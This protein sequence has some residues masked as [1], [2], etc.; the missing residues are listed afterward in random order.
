[1]NL[2]RNPLCDGIL[3]TFPRTAAL[4]KMAGGGAGC[5]RARAGLL[6]QAFCMQQPGDQR[7]TNDSRVYV[8]ALR[9]SICAI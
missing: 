9:D 8:R 6:P 5:C 1:M 2:H 3:N 7:N 4:R